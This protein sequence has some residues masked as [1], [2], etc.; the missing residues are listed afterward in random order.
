MDAL[1]HIREEE[2]QM[3]YIATLIG[4]ELDRVLEVP[5]IVLHVLQE[6]INMMTPILPRCSFIGDLLTTKMS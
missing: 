1:C 2:Y 3:T 6:F 4:I 5:N